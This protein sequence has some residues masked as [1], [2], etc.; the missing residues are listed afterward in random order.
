MGTDRA[1]FAGGHRDTADLWALVDADG[2]AGEAHPAA[3]AGPGASRRDL[4][5]AVH[6]LCTTHGARPGLPADARERTTGVDAEWL[7]AAAEGFAAERAYLSRVVA[8]A[9][10]QPSTPGQA[11]AEAALAGQ[12]HAFQ[13]LGRSDRAGVA[14]GAAAA[15]VLDWPAMRG[16]VDRAA[17]CFGE[18]PAT[19]RLPR[20]RDTAAALAALSPA[21][22]RAAL[23][24]AQQLLAQ[25]RGLWRL[26]EA[27]AAAR[28]SC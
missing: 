21:M 8:A 27:R 28:E 16:V 5:D 2:S 14:L 4:A 7:A 17:R 18:P 3:L 11:L 26:L 10:P 22:E 9:G 24:G 12:R 19:P 23:F 13:M 15:L 1:A 6:A 25:H 20:M